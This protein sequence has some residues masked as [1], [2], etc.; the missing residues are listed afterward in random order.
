MGIRLDES[1]ELAT[2][3]PAWGVDLLHISC[4]DAFKVRQTNL[5]TRVP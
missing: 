1:L 5:T 2:W 3:L 4:W